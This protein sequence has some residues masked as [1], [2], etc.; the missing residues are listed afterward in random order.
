MIPQGFIT[1]ISGG[2]LNECLI[3][4]F[5]ELHCLQKQMNQYQILLQQPQLLKQLTEFTIQKLTKNLKKQKRADEHRF[6]RIIRQIY[7]T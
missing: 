6:E 4:R 1:G 2:I 5:V 7:R 3:K